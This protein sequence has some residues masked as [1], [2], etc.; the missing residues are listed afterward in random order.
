MVDC[1]VLFTYTLLLRMARIFVVITYISC[2]VHNSGR[3]ASSELGAGSGASAGCSATCRV[4]TR[5]NYCRHNIKGGF[6]QDAN[7]TQCNAMQQ[8]MQPTEFPDISSY[9][10]SAPFISSQV[11]RHQE[12][13]KKFRQ[14]C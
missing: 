6:K 11:P 4:A 14:N 3:I 10:A 2:C 13:N 8:Y 7:A 5:I 9:S 1:P 12:T